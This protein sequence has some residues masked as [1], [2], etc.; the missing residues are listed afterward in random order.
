MPPEGYTTV[1]ISDE[2]A[3]KLARI[4]PATLQRSNMR[5]IQPLFKRTKSLYRS[6]FSCLLNE[7]KK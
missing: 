4:A 1:R 2:L 7:Q 6:W 3:E 5:L